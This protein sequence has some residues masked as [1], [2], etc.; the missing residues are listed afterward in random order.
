[1]VQNHYTKDICFLAGVFHE[2]IRSLKAGVVLVPV[3][4]V[5]TYFH[6]SIYTHFSLVLVKFKATNK[7]LR[8]YY[9]D[10]NKLSN[11]LHILALS[12]LAPK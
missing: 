9:I 3:F 10:V 5:I 1:M 4:S 7:K 11:S 2:G 8:N 6:I 12:C